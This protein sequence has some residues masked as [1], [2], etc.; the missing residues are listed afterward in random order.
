MKENEPLR[1]KISFFAH[2]TVCAVGA[3]AAAY[4]LFRYLLPAVLPFLVAWG[5]AFAARPLAR[6][7]LRGKRR[8]DGSP[9]GGERA[10]RAVLSLAFLLLGVGGLAYLL[11]R[12]AGEAV[13]FLSGLA[14]SGRLDEILASVLR[15]FGR[16]E[17]PAGSKIGE[18]LGSVVGALLAEVGGAVAAFAA[19]IP[20]GVFFAVVLLIATVYFSVDLERVNRAVMGLLPER[21]REVLRGYKASGLRVGLKYLRSYAFLTLI[22]FAVVLAGLLILRVDYAL[23]LAALI[24]LLDALPV[25]GVGTVIVPW[26]IAAFA[27]G[28][29]ALAVGLLILL[30]AN[31]ILRQFLEPKILGKNL[32]IHPLLTLVLLYAGYSFLGLFGL[33]VVPLFSIL[34]DPLIRRRAEAGDVGATKAEAAS[35]RAPEK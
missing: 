34:L 3:V 18:A 22:T 15:P 35:E 1:Q 16:P 12:L 21:A 13:S 27:S 20:E 28:K 6:K 33:L 7:I 30:A 5:I 8:P 31:E 29:T 14:E 23:L 9:T 17:D 32:G 11:G 25:L 4:L 2:L 19:K 26:S 24:A 10:L